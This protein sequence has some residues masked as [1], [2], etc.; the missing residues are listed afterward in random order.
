MHRMSEM[1][2]ITFGKGGRGG[3]VLIDRG[4]KHLEAVT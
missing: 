3:A 1:V 4:E 2:V